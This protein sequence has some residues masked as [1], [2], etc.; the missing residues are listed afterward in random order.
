MSTREWYKV[1]LDDQVLMT[2]QADLSPAHLT[3]FRVKLQDPAN[4]WI[5]T[6]RIARRKGL[7][8]DQTSFLFKLLHCL[9]PTQDRVR[10]L[11]VADVGQPGLCQLCNQEEE[12]T[13]HALFYC[14]HNVVA[15]HALLGYSQK[16]IPNLTPEDSIKLRLGNSLEEEEELA[17][18]SLLATGWDHIWKARTEKKQVC[19]FKMRAELEAMISVFR[20]SWYQQ[21]ENIMSEI[22]N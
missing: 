20:K 13:L 19:M 11:G 12:D 2:E 8:S 14:Q 1:L 22:I 16:I 21:S 10:R 18:I 17:A 15:G 3:P 9:L 5:E 6:L 4:D 7:A